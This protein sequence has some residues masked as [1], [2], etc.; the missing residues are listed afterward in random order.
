MSSDAFVYILEC[1]D[2][3]LYTGWTHDLDARLKSHNGG[4]TG[5]KYT[6]SRQPV[7]LVYSERRENKSAALRRE[8]EIKAL[9]RQAKLALI[10]S[11]KE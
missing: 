11:A 1:A 6:R 10:E 8:I 9:T 4:K 7:R 5:A 2:G 3:T